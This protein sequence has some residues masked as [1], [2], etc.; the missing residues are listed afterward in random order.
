VR[1]QKG[2]PS[3]QQA[4]LGGGGDERNGLDWKFSGRGVGSHRAYEAL[5]GGQRLVDAAGF[6]VH[7]RD[8]RLRLETCPYAAAR[9]AARLDFPASA[10]SSMD[11][12]YIILRASDAG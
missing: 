9:S 12:L 10:A 7:D 8:G 5:Q 11:A 2:L 4:L 1:L 3:K 6:R